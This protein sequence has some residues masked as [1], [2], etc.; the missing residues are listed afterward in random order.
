MG[1]STC[2]GG[3]VNGG[4][5]ASFPILLGG[6]PPKT[7]VAAS[8]DFTTVGDSTVDGDFT[9][10]SGT[11]VI[12]AGQREFDVQVQTAV[13]P[14]AGDRTFHIQL[15]N[16]QNVRLSTATASCTIHSTASGG[17]GERARRLDQ[18]HRP[19]AGA[20]VPSS[21]S[22]PATVQLE[23]DAADAAAVEPR[24]RVRPLAD[25]GRQRGRSG[26]L[27]RVLR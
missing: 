4:G 12:P 5:V 15:S 25:A 6:T 18:H 11:A 20:P 8:V 14:P 1:I 19:A 10:V 27:R 13:N 26:R 16:A 17:G 9:P 21:G 2:T 23:L 7:T 22:V 24:A 3:T